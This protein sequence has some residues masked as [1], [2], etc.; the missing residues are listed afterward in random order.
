MSTRD[1]SWGKGGRCEWLT[2]Y[3]PCSA[4]RRDDRQGKNLP[5]FQNVYSDTAVFPWGALDHSRP[6]STDGENGRS[7]TSAP[8][9]ALMTSG[10]TLPFHP[11]S[12][13]NK[14]RKVHL[15]VFRAAI[16]TAAR[17][18]PKGALRRSDKTWRTRHKTSM[19]VNGSY[20]VTLYV[21]LHMSDEENQNCG[22]E[23]HRMFSRV[24]ISRRS[25]VLRFLSSF[26]VFIL[27]QTLLR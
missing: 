18:K 12:C 26:I 9:H 22:R 4:E 7:C 24:E 11:V 21:H 17:A 19:Q 15:G 5:L 3:H 10:T 16:N 1:F 25:W 23:K 8:T 13:A 6:W 2:T 27:H 20:P 14:T